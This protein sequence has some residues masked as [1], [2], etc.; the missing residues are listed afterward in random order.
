MYVLLV[1]ISILLEHGYINFWD[2]IFLFIAGYFGMR[3]LMP[4][5]K[6]QR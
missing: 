6:H 1:P 2:G 5:E 3:L 4:E